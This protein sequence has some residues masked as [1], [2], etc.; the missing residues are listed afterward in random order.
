[1]G[2]LF[3]AVAADPVL[4]RRFAQPL[5]LLLQTR[6]LSRVI[7]NGSVACVV[8]C[9]DAAVGSRLTPRGSTER[10]NTESRRPSSWT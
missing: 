9:H 2:R 3:A 5:V 10:R 6:N 1:V 8:A 7:R 4:L